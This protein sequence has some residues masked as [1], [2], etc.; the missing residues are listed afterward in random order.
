MDEVPEA[1][2]KVFRELR[3]LAVECFCSRVLKD[4]ELVLRD[5]SRNYH[6]RFLKCFSVPP[7]QRRDARERL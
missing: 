1:D 5:T 2:W 7:A 6:Q 4:L 3:E